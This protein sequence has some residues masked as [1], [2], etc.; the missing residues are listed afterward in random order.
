[1]TGPLAREPSPP[2][3]EQRSARQS[4]TCA[5]ESVRRWCRVPGMRSPC[6][7]VGC[8]VV[9]QCA[10]QPRRS[11]T[12]GPGCCS[13][14]GF[15]DLAS[16]SPLAQ[17]EAVVVDSRCPPLDGTSQPTCDSTVVTAILIAPLAELGPRS[18]QVSDGLHG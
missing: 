14:G 9:P 5:A 3:P 10:G 13:A 2:C 17:A 7:S 1:M 6:E 16:S 12:A 11:L 8:S 18:A 15:G 4:S